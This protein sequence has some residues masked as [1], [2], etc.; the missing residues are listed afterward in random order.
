MEMFMKEISK[1]VKDMGKV[2]IFMLMVKFIK[3]NGHKEKNMVKEHINGQTDKNLQG[4]L[5]K[6]RGKKVNGSTHFYQFEG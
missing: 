4:N 1:M 3:E 2:N 5:K 6:I